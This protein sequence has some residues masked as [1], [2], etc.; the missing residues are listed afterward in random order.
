[1]HAAL[2]VLNEG[3]TPFLVFWPGQDAGAEGSS[4]AIREFKAIAPFR[5][6]RTLP[7]ERFLR[8]MAQT[9]MLI[10]NS[11]TGIRECSYIG[12]PSMNLGKRQAGRERGANVEDHSLASTTLLWMHR[13][14]RTSN[15][16]GD[17]YASPKIAATLK[18]LL[19][20]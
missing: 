8:L 3:D 19:C 7:P 20:R 1:M 16:Y 14:K 5:T 13:E 12:T 6:V 11:S 10:G 2:T 9:E 4:K 17:G 15:L 18:E